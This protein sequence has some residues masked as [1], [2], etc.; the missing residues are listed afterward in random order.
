[1]R[2]FIALNLPMTEKRKI[3]KAAQPL[4]DAG[5]PVRWLEP[6]DYHLTLKF[7]GDVRNELLSV[8]EGVIMRVAQ[9]TKEF[10]LSISGFGAFPTIRRP[11]VIWI[12][13]EPTPALRCLKQD[14]EWGLANHGFDRETRAFHPHITLGK[15]DEEEGAGA[16]R[17]L[18]DLAAG[19]SYKGKVPMK[20]V[21]LMRSQLSRQGTN[22]SLI[23]GSPLKASSRRKK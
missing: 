19:L 14:L 4:R 5:Y 20:T 9:E 2:L 7:L 18:D 11:R 10:P 6:A 1:M 3:Y 22:Y 8:A 15:A 16:F 23:G 13:A 21:D 17:G 12:G